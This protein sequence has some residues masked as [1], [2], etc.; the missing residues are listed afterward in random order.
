[1]RLNQNDLD[2]VV[3]ERPVGRRDRG[4]TVERL[5]D[6]HPVEGIAMQRR[7]AGGQPRVLKRWGD[8]LKTQLRKT[9]GQTSGNS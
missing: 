1:M 9:L 2:P 7:K 6:N 4:A 5:G 3:G 8:Q